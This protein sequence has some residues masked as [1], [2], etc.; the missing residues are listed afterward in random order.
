MKWSSSL[1]AKDFIFVGIEIICT[2]HGKNTNDIYTKYSYIQSEEKSGH[3]SNSREQDTWTSVLLQSVVITPSSLTARGRS[4]SGL[5]AFESSCLLVK[6]AWPA[7]VC[8]FSL[9]H[10]LALVLLKMQ[11]CR[12]ERFGRPRAF[13]FGRNWRSLNLP[14]CSGSGVRRVWSK[15]CR[16]I[17][18]I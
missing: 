4:Q 3:C 9:D 11:I 10:L 18:A 1:E 12:S 16:L 14:L 2:E 7:F 13:S 8:R 17:L 5:I 15:I 6:G